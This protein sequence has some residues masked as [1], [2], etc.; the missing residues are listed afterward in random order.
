MRLVRVLLAS[1]LPLEQ[2]HFPVLKNTR[3]KIMKE[4][5]RVQKELN[6]QATRNKDWAALA[7][8]LAILF[9]HSHVLPLSQGWLQFCSLC[10]VRL[11]LAALRPIG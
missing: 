11:L 5:H 10:L 4:A 6:R 2:K 8:W 7:T 9:L 3:D 1:F